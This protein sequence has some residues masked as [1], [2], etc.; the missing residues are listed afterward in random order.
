M[1]VKGGAVMDLWTG[2]KLIQLDKN[3]VPRI[4]VTYSRLFKYT[5]QHTV[6][7]REQHWVRTLTAAPVYIRTFSLPHKYTIQLRPSEEVNIQNCQ[8]H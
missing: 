5:Q 6:G 3:W 4:G 2:P 1:K 7:C 8:P